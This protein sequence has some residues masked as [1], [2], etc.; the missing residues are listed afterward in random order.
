M[1]TLLKR[2]AESAQERGR[3]HES[4]FKVLGHHCAGARIALEAALEATYKSNRGDS[5]W[6]TDM[7]TALLAELDPQHQ[8]KAGRP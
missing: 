5:W 2:L 7:L 1:A 6:Y 3:A 8:G 4:T